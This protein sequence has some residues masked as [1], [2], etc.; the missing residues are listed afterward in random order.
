MARARWWFQEDG[1]DLQAHGME[2]ASMHAGEKADEAV[3]LSRVE[4][5]LQEWAWRFSRSD[6][7]G[8]HQHSQQQQI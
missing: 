6:Q 4:G 1:E 3:G 2:G 7:A 5:E 8:G